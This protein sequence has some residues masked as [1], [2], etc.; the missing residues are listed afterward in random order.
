MNEENMIDKSLLDYLDNYS[1][2]TLQKTAMILLEKSLSRS[3]SFKTKQVPLPPINLVQ[4]SNISEKESSKHEISS[5]ESSDS[6][7]CN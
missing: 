2:D 4:S 3:K 7:P 6:K 5:E 1:T